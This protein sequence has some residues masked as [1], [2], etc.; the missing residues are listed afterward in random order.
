MGKWFARTGNRS[1]IFLAT[2]FGIDL[3]GGFN[4]RG[5]PEYVREAVDKALKRLQTD[6]IDL[7]YLHRPDN[8]VPIEITVRTMKEFV[9]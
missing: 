1:K 3:T 5:D 6:Y 7:L 4:L 9:E 2:K 8:K